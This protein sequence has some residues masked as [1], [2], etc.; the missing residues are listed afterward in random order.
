[1]NVRTVFFRMLFVSL[2]AG[3]TV[4]GC[5]SAGGM[6]SSLPQSVARVGASPATASD[7]EVALDQA[8]LRAHRN[9]VGTTEY[10]VIDGKWVA[11]QPAPGRPG[12]YIVDGEVVPGPP[13]DSP[14]VSETQPQA[15]AAASP[16]ATPTPN[17]STFEGNV[18]PPCTATGP[19]RR[20]YSPPNYS[21]ALANVTFPAPILTM[22]LNP[23]Y[24]GDT[25]FIYM[26]GWLSTAT[27]AGN[28]EFGFQYS[29]DN[30]WYS[31]YARTNNPKEYYIYELDGKPV[32]YLSSQ[33]VTFAMAGYVV[34]TQDELHMAALGTADIL[35]QLPG[36][37]KMTHTCLSHDHVPDN[38]WA[39]SRCCI[40]ARMTSIGQ[41]NPKDMNWFYD[42]VKFGPIAWS[43]AELAATAPTPMPSS[44]ILPFEKEPAW[45][46]AGVQNWP[47]LQ[48]KIAVSYTSAAAET[49]TINL[50][51]LPD[52]QVSL[53]PSGCQYYKNQTSATV[54]YTAKASNT[55]AVPTYYAWGPGDSLMTVPGATLNPVYG[56]WVGK[57][58]TATW[59][60]GIGGGVNSRVYTAWVDMLFTDATGELTSQWYSPGDDS[61]H[62]VTDD[63][64]IALGS[65]N[66]CPSPSPSPK[67]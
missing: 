38:G 61:G 39:P 31:L 46:A 30:F 27:D 3:A 1:M 8:V 60:G 32:H 45:T 67:A 54:N 33:T 12:Y 22:P 47:P 55:T 16:K 18:P 43:G 52:E 2:A 65:S 41:T 48:N 29:A 11:Q 13:D 25:G 58:N 10:G 5:S 63:D 51:A 26:E 20:V 64:E 44:T 37:T 15:A 40:M 56:L 49:D 7:G 17:C 35:C 14:P 4:A 21:Y 36:S 23:P 59:K 24:H 9:V 66:L 42:G 57:G 62:I 53:S 34:G 50:N 19:F 6:R 28:S